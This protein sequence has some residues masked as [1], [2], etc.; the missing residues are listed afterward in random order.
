MLT[1]GWSCCS[2]VARTPLPPFV[3]SCVVMALSLGLV[4]YRPRNRDA[5]PGAGGG[6]EDVAAAS[7]APVPLGRGG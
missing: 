2:R 1:S 3:A 6:T 7:W 4:L 5:D